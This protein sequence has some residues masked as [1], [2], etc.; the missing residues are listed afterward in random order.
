MVW[1]E[2]TVHF[3]ATALSVKITGNAMGIWY[4]CVRHTVRTG[5]GF[6]EL[7]VTGSWQRTVKPVCLSV[8]EVR[9]AAPPYI[10]IPLYLDTFLRLTNF[11]K[12]FAGST[13]YNFYDKPHIT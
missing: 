11:R 8:A 12:I 5:Y 2:T 13:K 4:F 1:T 10:Y 9:K 7:F 3:A 6:W